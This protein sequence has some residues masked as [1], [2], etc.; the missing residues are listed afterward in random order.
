VLAAWLLPSAP[1][2]AGLYNT[3]E[4]LIDLVAGH[5]AEYSRFLVGLQQVVAVDFTNVK[6]SPRY[7]VLQ[8]VKQ[9]E[10]ELNEGRLSA[11]GRVNLSALYVRLNEP[12]KAVT[13]LEAVPRKE[14]DFT[15]L[16]N[17][18]T[19]Y[20]LTG[21]LVRA[22]TY[23]AEA[24]DNWPKVAP[25]GMNTSS[26]QLNFLHVVEGYHLRLIRSRLREQANPRGQPASIDAIFPNLRLVGPSGEY[27]PGLLAADQWAHLPAAHR[28]IVKLL[29][30]WM[31]HDTRL[32]WLLA[33]IVNAAGDPELAL[34]MMDELAWT[35]R[36][37]NPEF[38]AHLHTL[39]RAKDTADRFR[40]LRRDLLEEKA[41]L[42]LTPL[43]GLLPPGPGVGL[44][45]IGTL[46]A[47]ERIGDKPLPE[48]EIPAAP[49]ATTSPATAPAPSAAW[50][51][52]WRQI[53]VSFVAGAVVAALL[54]LQL[55]EMRKRK[56]DTQP[57]SQE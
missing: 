3:E 11:R 41:A 17:L 2:R 53:G 36:F 24:L 51:P 10:E 28:E 44:D 7:Q 1:A 46:A 55:R 26:Q 18:A 34:Q 43:V 12:E 23:L 32:R 15:A 56:Q 47:L 54:S 16:S 14:R 57:A 50:T 52:E 45:A 37:G 22:E 27:E 29:V 8:R 38:D 42:P 35:R 20:Q 6:D 13:L 30:L 19:A 40:L 25:A 31:P 5:P 49:P 9:L 33:E 48:R 4:R 21:N 39:R